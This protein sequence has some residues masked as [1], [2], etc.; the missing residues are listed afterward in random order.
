LAKL[1]ES[2]TALTQSISVMGTANYMSPEQASGQARQ[3]TTA[4]DVYSLG[5]ILFELLTGRPP[6]QA[7]NV[8]ATLRKVIN[9]EPPRPSSIKSSINR[10]LETICLKCLN[11]NPQHRYSSA[12]ALAEDLDRSCRHEP[13]LARPTGI[14]EH[15]AKAARRRPAVTALSGAM[16][17][18]LMLGAAG[19]LSQW[20]RAEEN[21]TQSR[22]RLVHSYVANGVKPEDV[23]DNIMASAH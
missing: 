21:A 8:I 7:E 5:A 4:A 17:V 13:I 19:I 1:L 2:D 16:V 15:F 23:Y 10:D 6:F 12:Q 20:R 22:S 11:K 18:A 14:W 9:E 3:V